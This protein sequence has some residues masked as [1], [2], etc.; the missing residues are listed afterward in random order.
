MRGPRRCR[1][2]SSSVTEEDAAPARDGASAIR[3]RRAVARPGPRSPQQVRLLGC[4]RWV[5]GHDDTGGGGTVR[6][7]AYTVSVGSS[8]TVEVSLSADPERT[9]VIPIT[10]TNQ[11]GVTTA[12][13]SGCQPA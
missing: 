11:G 13:Y 4:S 10:V 6:G 7:A 1:V 9:V 5:C 3:T 8:A 2:G 12:D